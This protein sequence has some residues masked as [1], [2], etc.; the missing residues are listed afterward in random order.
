LAQFQSWGIASIA[1]DEPAY[2][3]AFT[4]WYLFSW[5]PDDTG[6][7]ESS[8][9]TK[10]SDN[11]IAFD[12]LDAHR[13]NLD[14]VA[15]NIIK[16]GTKSP[17]S[18]YTIVKVVSEYRLQIQELYTGQT[19]MVNALSTVSYSQGDVLFSA[20]LS[21]NTMA[22]LLGCMPMALNS[23]TREKVLAHREKWRA[24]E[25]KAID[26][27]LLYLHDTELRR[28]YFMLLNQAQKAQLH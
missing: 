28:F 17:Y 15:Q 11:A 2:K 3:A 4:A 8:F 16:V 10:P 12:Y 20:V 19:L 21:V 27:R 25:G 7:N 24:E 22:I 14:P 23:K 26:S 13:D 6:I 5:L 18:F 1:R 9:K